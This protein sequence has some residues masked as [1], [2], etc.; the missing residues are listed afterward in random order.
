MIAEVI[1][2]TKNV[3]ESRSALVHCHFFTQP[4]NLL[5]GMFLT[6]QIDISSEDAV[7]LPEAAVVR[8]DNRQVGL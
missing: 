7:T 1:L 8:Y 2:V 4:K 6:A 3:D 5:P